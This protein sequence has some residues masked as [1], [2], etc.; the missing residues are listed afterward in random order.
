M[1]RLPILIVAI[2]LATS[3]VGQTSQLQPRN[4]NTSSDRSVVE[5]VLSTVVQLVREAAIN[6]TSDSIGSRMLE[7]SDR[8]ALQTGSLRDESLHNTDDILGILRQVKRDLSA[9][10]LNLDEES[11]RTTAE[12]LRTL[13][14]KIDEA[15]IL[16]DESQE[17]DGY[18]HDSTRERMQ[19]REDGEWYSYS[20]SVNEYRFDSD[21]HEHDHEDE[22]DWWARSRRYH[23]G[24]AG[25]RHGWETHTGEFTSSWPFRS[26]ALYYT[27]PSVRYNR[28]EGLVLGFRK[29]PLEWDSYDRST[30]FGNAV[31]SFG[32]DDFQYEIGGETRTR[33]H[34]SDDGIDFKI[35]GSYRKAT[36]T[37]DTWKIGWAENSLAAF[38]FNY[39]YYDYFQVEGWNVYGILRASPLVQLSGGFRAE[40]YSDLQ[41]NTSWSLFGG[42][43]F[44][45]NPTIERASN[46]MRSA[47]V[48]LEGGS[49]RNLSELPSGFAFRGEAEFGQGLGGDFSFNRYFGDVRAYLPTSHVSTLAFRAVGGL[50][51]GDVPY[52]KGFTLGGVGSVRAY[53]QNVFFGTRMLLGNAEFSIL[54]DW[55]FDDWM[56]SGFFDAGWVNGEASNEFS[57]DDVFTSAGLGV[58]FWDRSMRLE[59]AWP[60]TN[61]GTDRDPQVWLRLSP[62]F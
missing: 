51:T 4:T 36:T 31:Y 34:D 40:S 35:G 18:A 15:L 13:E 24:T 44:R 59:V 54:Q 46:D 20:D 3:A 47:V 42:N 56:L 48:T 52:Q 33:S 61:L 45:P 30:V 9:L 11:P 10:R 17:S 57:I 62:S 23:D 28:V 1:S 25:V 27:S 53:P 6:P 50:S 60:L 39:D 21:L 55:I 49:V 26:S 19:D 58:G 7:M 32:L 43:H 8:L 38:L 12:K 37:N 14:S 5:T 41:Q 2:A 22:D 16:I 29:L